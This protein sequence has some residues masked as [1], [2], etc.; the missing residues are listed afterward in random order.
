MTQ[1][2][3]RKPYQSK[4]SIRPSIQRALDAGDIQGVIDNL[5]VR[6]RRFVEE[7]LIDFNASAACQRAGYVTKYPNRMGSQLVKNPGVKAAIDQMTLE[8][9]DKSIVKPDYVLNKIKRTIEKAEQDNNHA[10]VLRGCE[11]IAR[12][13][14]MFI[15][16]TEISGPNG[17]AI[18]YERV[19][20]AADAFTSAISGLIER[21]GAG[22]VPLV[23]ERRD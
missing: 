5:T 23:V 6:Q 12:H 14:G 10:A 8:R 22:T 15:E 13:L 21:S 19:K 11:L 9:A 18:K 7:Y 17:D 4:D 16:R 2:R 20:E 1:I 3:V